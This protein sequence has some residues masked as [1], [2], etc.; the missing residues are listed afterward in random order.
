MSKTSILKFKKQ[1]LIV[2]FGVFSVTVVAQ[3]AKAV[4]FIVE[5]SDIQALDELKANLE[6]NTLSVEQLKQK[7]KEMN[8]PFESEVNGVLYQL[9]GFEEETG[10]PL[11]YVTY[12]KAAAFGTST[13][14]LY[15]DSTTFKLTGKGMR[16]YEWDGGGVLTTHQELKGRVTQKD[17]PG[18]TSDH[19]THV[20]GT[21]IAS[22]VKTYNNIKGAAKGMAYEA[23]LNSYDWNRNFYEMA[24]ATKEGALLSNHSY[25]YSA[26]FEYSYRSGNRGWHWLGKDSET[27]DK[28]FGK[29][30]SIDRQWD[31][32]AYISPYHLMVLAAGNSR[33]DAP[34][35]GESHYVRDDDNNWI[36]STKVRQ[37]NGGTLGYDCITFGTLS[38]NTLAVGAA[39][40][41]NYREYSQ[42]SDV[43]MA[44]FSSFGPADDGRIKPDI[45]GIGVDIYSCINSYNSSYA[46][47]SGTSM[48]SPN[49][50]GSLLLLQ[51]HY[52]NVNN[53]IFMRAATLKALA[54]ATAN[55]AGSNPGPDYRS[56]WGLL[57]TYKAAVAI[58]DNG[59][60]SLIA[61][62]TLKNGS[63]NEI[64]VKALGT[65]PLKVTI[66]WNDPV[67]QKMPSASVLN[68]RTPVLVNDLDL[69]IKY[70]EE[71]FF[72]WKL[73]P[74]N[75]SAAATKGDNTVDNVEQVVIEQPEAGAIYTVTVSHKNNIRQSIVG[76]SEAGNMIVEMGRG[77]GDQLYSMIITGI[78]MGNNTTPPDTVVAEELADGVLK[79]YP[80]PSD[81]KFTIY[82]NNGDSPL[83][84]R[85]YGIAG[86]MVLNQEYTGK[87]IEMNLT[88][89]NKG[90]YIIETVNKDTKVKR[91][92]KI[93]IK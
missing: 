86:N 61:E 29:Y 34:S 52:K 42:P 88:G 76:Y 70:K 2:L 65:E 63:I 17:N 44:S 7:A 93:I 21:L 40:K 27:E 6:K 92:G 31:G 69:R 85:V 11:Y 15:P 68:D 26:G 37:R 81:G 82:A 62:D 43:R 58:S 56:G 22:G 5:H 8:I 13:S 1:M 12:N 84:V 32:I 83:Q 3:D 71:T 89:L 67:P 20:A 55:E 91:R 9:A 23:E 49:V 66:C 28:N 73:D 54:I 18:K 60:K 48:A 87:Q 77:S 50:T 59:K 36:V 75:P 33:G 80:N 4:R 30:N 45:T 19:S 39:H 79:I 35:S 14:K 72:P 24:N 57:N 51:E 90:V 38:K 46:S 10:R 25:G 53:G 47:Y 16:V 78:E 41:L 74:D 64:K